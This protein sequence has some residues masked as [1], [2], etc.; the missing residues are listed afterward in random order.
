MKNRVSVVMS[1]YNEKVE[2]LRKSINSILEQTYENFEFIIILDNPFNLELKDYLLKICELDDRVKV[3]INEKN[4]GIVE[5]INRGI[6]VAEG[7][8][9]ARM[10]ADDIAVKERLEKQ[11][12][13]LDNNPNIHLVGSKMIFIDEE[14]NKLYE[15]QYKLEKKEEIIEHLKY[16]NA[17]SH[18]TFMF[19]R[20]TII[21]LGKYRNA[22]YA[23]DYDLC[24]RLVV[25]GYEISN[26]P[27]V[28][29]Y[30]R[31]R[32]SGIS[33]GKKKYQITTTLYLQKIYCSSLNDK[34]DYFNEEELK[35]LLNK[36]DSKLG[37]FI[38]NLHIKAIEN[39][40]NK[41]K[42]MIYTSIVIIL[43][44][45]YLTYYIKRLRLKIYLKKINL[46]CI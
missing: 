20:K 34:I 29:L 6:D 43:S 21:D 41:V 32:D 38:E 22:L 14:G 25:Q 19:R 31:L 30:Y 5:S 42:R 39:K 44:K 11:V 23:E 1:A 13:F 7:E 40:K 15:D 33:L 26:I 37:M 36:D 2:W 17:F 3:I 18:P 4:L 24:M 16:C 12:I 28:L 35:L 46:L 10:D 45:K 8:Y 27:E 9:I